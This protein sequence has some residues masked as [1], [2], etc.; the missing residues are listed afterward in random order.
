MFAPQSDSTRYSLP[1]PTLNLLKAESSKSKKGRKSIYNIILQRPEQR[2]SS[3]MQNPFR[4]T[5]EL[6]MVE[7]PLGDYHY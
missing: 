3:L 4:R 2:W 7:S 5:N 1:A 6:T